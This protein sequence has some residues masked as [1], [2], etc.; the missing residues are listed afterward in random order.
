MTERGE[1][2]YAKL[3]LSLGVPERSVKQ[4]LHHFRA[5]YRS[6]LR[7][8]ISQTVE[9]AADVDDETRYLCEVLASSGA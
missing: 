5:R 7:D 8:E 3:S 2:S 1:V 6:I 9:T 4:L